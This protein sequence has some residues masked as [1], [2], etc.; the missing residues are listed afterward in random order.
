M[1]SNEVTDSDSEEYSSEE[2]DSDGGPRTSR[3]KRRVKKVV[4]KQDMTIQKHRRQLHGMMYKLKMSVDFADLMKEV[5]KGEVPK[6]PIR[7]LLM[8]EP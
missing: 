6:S 5:K 4:D 7:S 3:P 2:S 8:D 1:K